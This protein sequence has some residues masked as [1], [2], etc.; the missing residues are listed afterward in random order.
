[1]RL[2][3]IAIPLH[4]PAHHVDVPMLQHEHDGPLL[5]RGRLGG[6]QF[7]CGSVFCRREICVDAKLPEGAF[8]EDMMGYDVD[9]YVHYL[10]GVYLIP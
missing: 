4:P 3:S 8:C 2:V 6:A 1:M 9:V 5:E 7:E 10:F